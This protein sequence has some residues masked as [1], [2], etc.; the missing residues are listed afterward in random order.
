MNIAGNGC[1]TNFLVCPYLLSHFE[2]TC[3]ICLQ[4][5][6]GI[7]PFVETVSSL[8]PLSYKLIVICLFWIFQLW[9][10]ITFYI[11]GKLAKSGEL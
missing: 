8:M 10:L 2:I 5:P 3:C 9:V 6:C 7:E 4:K 1:L 11:F